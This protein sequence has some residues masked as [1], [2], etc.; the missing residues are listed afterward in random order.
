MVFSVQNQQ[1]IA[2]TKEGSQ[3]PTLYVIKLMQSNKSL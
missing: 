3:L 2:L 1:V